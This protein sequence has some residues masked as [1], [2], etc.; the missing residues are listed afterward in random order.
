MVEKETL[1]FITF[2]SIKGLF[3]KSKFFSKIMNILFFYQNH[4]Y[5]EIKYKS[6]GIIRTVE[7][8]RSIL[9]IYFFLTQPK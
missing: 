2:P 9:K 5:I 4:E 6:Y 8:A 3:L 1:F 7:P